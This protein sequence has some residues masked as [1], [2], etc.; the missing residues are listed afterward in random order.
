MI[1]EK[2][3]AYLNAGGRGARLEGSVEADPNQGISKAML[4]IGNPPIKL[5]DHQLNVL[6][7]AGVEQ[8]VV[9]VGDHKRVKDYV[10]G[11][12]SSDVVQVAYNPEQA[13]T[14]GDL[15]TAVRTAK[16]RRFLMVQNVDTIL[17]IDHANF[18]AHHQEHDSALSIALTT[19]RNVPNQDAFMVATDG[20]VLFSEEAKRKVSAPLESEVA[21][22]ASSTGALMIDRSYLESLNWRQADGQLSLYSDVVGDAIGKRELSA[23]YNGDNFFLDVGT[24]E[25]LQIARDSTSS[26]QHFIRR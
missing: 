16:M 25:T 8:I 21:Y 2:V 3:T 14:G 7:E 23:Y 12:Y 26:L 6:K 1:H 24:P 10:E 18:S 13:G 20:I 22:L 19:Q 17:E 15:I 4:E 9:G 5:I 11:L